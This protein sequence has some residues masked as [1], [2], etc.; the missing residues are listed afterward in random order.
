[1]AFGTVN[2]MIEKLHTCALSLSVSLALYACMSRSAKLFM[3][4]ISCSLPQPLLG[5]SSGRVL[6]EQTRMIES[7]AGEPLDHIH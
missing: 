3:L 1:M 6:E 5:R 7:R 4:V 2:L